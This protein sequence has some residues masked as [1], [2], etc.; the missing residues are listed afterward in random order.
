MRL[1]KGAGRRAK[2]GSNGCGL[3]VRWG[4]AHAPLPG[5]GAVAICPW[6]REGRLGVG[7]FKEGLGLVKQSS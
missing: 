7:L 6:V 5:C 1:R 3:A 2:P 4:A